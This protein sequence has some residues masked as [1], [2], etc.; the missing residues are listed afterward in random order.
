MKKTWRAFNRGRECYV[1]GHLQQGIPAP[2]STSGDIT[3]V[4]SPSVAKVTAVLA[5]HQL[6]WSYEIKLQ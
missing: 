3:V 6:F 1:E 4:F 5:D 2:I